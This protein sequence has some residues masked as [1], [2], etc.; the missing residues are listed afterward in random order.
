MDPL[1]RLWNDPD[2]LPEAGD[3][4]WWRAM[5][6]CPQDPRH[7]AEGNVAIHTRMVLEALRDDPR[8]RDLSRTDRTILALAALLHDIGKPA[9]TRV[10]PD[11]RIGAPGHARA[12][13]LQARRLLWEADIPPAIREAVCGLVRWHMRPGFLV[14]D[15]DPER[16]VLT[17]AESARCDHLALLADADTRGRIAPDTDAARERVRFF[18]AFCTETGC[19][20][21]P[22]PF[23]SDHSRFVYYRTPG[24]DPRYAAWDDTRAEM[25]LLSGLPGAGKDT[26]RA[27][28]F[29]ELPEVCLD[30]IRAAHGLSPTGSQAEVAR[31]ARDA[32]SVFLRAGQPFVWNA[33]H[34]RADLRERAIGLAAAHGFRVRIVY[35]EAPRDRLLLQNRSRMAAVPDA[36]MERYL[37][38]WEVP[39]RSEAHTREMPWDQ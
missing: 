30:T 36:A 29:A 24:R 5:E 14:D 22:F 3:A 28:R 23:A 8:W 38:R 7:H 20:D 35:V 6:A 12:G 33:T 10:E 2:R 4:P 18:A 27:A 1:T 19:L 17:I 11:G 34:L 15:A 21:Q 25:V 39:V 26:V 37:D 13:A 31:R 9:T 32:A 16:T